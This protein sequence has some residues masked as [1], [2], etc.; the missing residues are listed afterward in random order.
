MKETESITS[1]HLYEI[2]NEG[3][4]KINMTEKFYK[5]HE[6]CILLGGCYRVM[7]KPKRKWHQVLF[8]FITFGIYKAPWIYEIKPI[9]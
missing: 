8:Q 2:P 6:T 1:D 3:T 7:S 5:E 4:F 9:D